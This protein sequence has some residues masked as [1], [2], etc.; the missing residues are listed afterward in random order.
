MAVEN[1]SMLR[2]LNNIQIINPSDESITLKLVDEI[3]EKPYPRYVQF[4]KFIDGKMYSEDEIDFTKGFVTKGEGDVLVITF[5]IMA[6]KINSMNLPVRV[7]DCFC[8]P[9]DEELLLKEVSQ[10]K[11]I[12][13]VE[14]NVLK[15]GLG[16]MVL[17]LLNDRN[18]NIPVFRKGLRFSDG[19]PKI[20]TNRDLLFKEEDLL[21]GEIENFLRKVCEK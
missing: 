13:T 19:Y 11:R 20:Y 8:L 18:I 3:L 1:M 4:D 5:G 15:G 14:D 6:K 17:E 2:T 12:V 21:D 9:I 16:S 7:I 10:A